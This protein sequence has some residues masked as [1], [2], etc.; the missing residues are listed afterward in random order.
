MLNTVD[1]VVQMTRPGEQQRADLI[2]RSAHF[3][4]PAF[5]PVGSE[6]SA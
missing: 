5:P 1:S 6:I 3:R 2:D 4:C